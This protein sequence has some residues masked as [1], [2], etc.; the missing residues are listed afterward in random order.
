VRD[1]PNTTTDQY[2]LYAQDQ[3]RLAGGALELTPAVRVDYYELAPDVDAVFTADN[4]GVSVTDLEETSV[5]PKLGA[6]W[7]F[8]D[9][10]SVYASYARGFRAPPYNDVNIGFTNLAFGY[11]A[12]ANP[13]LKPETS[14]GYEVGLRGESGSAFFAVSGFYN[15]YKDFIASLSFVRV[16]N[17]LQIFQSQNFS[18]AHIY[19]AELRAGLSLLDN[20]MR[21]RSSIAYAR[22]A[23]RNEGQSADQPLN[24]VDPLK[25]VLGIA[26]QPSSTWSIEVIGTAVDRHQHV[27]QATPQFVP[28]GYF[29]VDVLAQASLG[30]NT[31]VNLGVFNLTDEKYWEW[32]DVRGVSPASL[33]RDRYTRPGLNVGASVA[34]QF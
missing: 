20:R 21:I 17:G 5:S 31:Q 7:Y 19:G 26:Y 3:I 15:D 14:D 8:N 9:E 1:F 13:D 23:G 29:I 27:N 24:S 18:E 22:G 12:I 25:G 34:V 30:W 11:T 28:A 33:V 2:A 4:P 32:S 10:L 16:E 6:I